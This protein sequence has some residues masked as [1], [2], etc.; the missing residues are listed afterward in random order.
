M[1]YNVLQVMRTKI[2][3]FRATEEMIKDIEE[4]IIEARHYRNR[5]DLINEVLR[6]FIRNYRQNSNLELNSKVRKK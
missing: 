2:V 1:I 5:S 6:N 3:N 4:I